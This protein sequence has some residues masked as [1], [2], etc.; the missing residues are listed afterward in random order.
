MEVLQSD[1]CKCWTFAPAIAD[2]KSSTQS[3]QNLFNGEYLKTQVAHNSLYTFDLN[4]SQSHFLSLQL[5]RVL[6]KY[7]H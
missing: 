4:L 7:I 6:E 1:S 3:I 5:R 2:K